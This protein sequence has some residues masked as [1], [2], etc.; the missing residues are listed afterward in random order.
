MF[1]SAL[2]SPE[3]K[4]LKKIKKI[5]SHEGPGAYGRKMMMMLEK[6]PC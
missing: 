5:T 1:F 6:R 4:F 3:L 2:I